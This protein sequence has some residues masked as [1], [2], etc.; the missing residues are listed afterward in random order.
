MSTIP[1]PILK[2]P[3][4]LLENIKIGTKTWFIKGHKVSVFRQ[5]HGFS[6]LLNFGEGIGV[7]FAF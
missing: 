5:N 3:S 6:V 1:S 2:T 7:V 4:N